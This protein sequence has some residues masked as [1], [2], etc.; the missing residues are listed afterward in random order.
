M[1][2]PHDLF[3]YSIWNN[4]AGYDIFVQ[5]PDVTTLLTFLESMQRRDMHIS[6]GVYVNTRANTGNDDVQEETGDAATVAE[7]DDAVPEIS[8][9]PLPLWSD[10]RHTPS[11]WQKLQP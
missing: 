6:T 1:D 10:S 8:H 5:Q 4:Q 7:A 2:S 9:P 11:L 3:E